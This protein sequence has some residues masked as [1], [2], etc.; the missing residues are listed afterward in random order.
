MESGANRSPQTKKGDVA[1]KP[2]YYWLGGV[3]LY[4]VP[5]LTMLVYLLANGLNRPVLGALLW[6][7]RIFMLEG[8]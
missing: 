3:A 2:I 1:M 4:V 7:I 8:R 5:A 6:P